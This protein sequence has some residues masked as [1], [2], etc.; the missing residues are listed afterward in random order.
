MHVTG[1]VETA[2]G[3]ST[4]QPASGEHI[5][6]SVT[7]RT[8][9]VY[10]LAR[11]S[12]KARCAPYLAGRLQQPQPHHHYSGTSHRG[13]LSLAFLFGCLSSCVCVC[14]FVCVRERERERE[15]TRQTDK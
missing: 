10:T 3:G 4:S 9:P 14:V 7:D 1:I 13:S 12:Q 6:D 8:F 15:R 11:C 5:L 2:R